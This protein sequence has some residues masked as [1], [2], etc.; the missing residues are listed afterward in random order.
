MFSTSLIQ[1]V[2]KCSCSV[3]VTADM[4]HLYYAKMGTAGMWAGA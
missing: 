2:N 3:I 1:K 4:K